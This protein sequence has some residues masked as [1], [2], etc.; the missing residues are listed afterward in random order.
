[1]KYHKLTFS[2]TA[3]IAH[4]VVGPPDVDRYHPFG[5]PSTGRNL[6]ASLHGR[7]LPS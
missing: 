5:L 4:A 6:D 2:T 7:I 3:A 1:M